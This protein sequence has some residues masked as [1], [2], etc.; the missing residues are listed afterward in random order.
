MKFYSTKFIA[1]LYFIISTTTL[2]PTYANSGE[3]YLDMEKNYHNNLEIL[4][5]TTNLFK[6]DGR[7]KASIGTVLYTYASNG[8]TYI[9][10]G[11]ENATK[12][13]G[14][15]YCELGGSLE[16]IKPGHAESFLT[17][18][19]RE[20]EEESAGTYKIDK[21]YALKN[22]FTI[23]RKKPERDE[24]YIFL[25][26]PLYVSSDELMKA[27]NQAA[28][29]H[30][31]EKDKFIWASLSNLMQNCLFSSQCEVKDIEGKKEEITLRPYFLNILKTNDM[32]AVIQAI[33]YFKN[34]QVLN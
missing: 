33:E 17:G 7:P 12:K 6:E 23:F 13:G 1:I 32:L 15:Q 27:V 5:S 2:F 20:C 9:L 34:K 25:K 28:D 10:I 30:S 26:A 8:E 19:I 16:L 4:N 29:S 18:C 3:F 14:S 11:R 21:E 31:T 22:S 24:V